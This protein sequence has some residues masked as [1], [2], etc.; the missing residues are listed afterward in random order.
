[1]GI[2][3]DNGDRISLWESLKVT[4]SMRSR[5]CSIPMLKAR[6]RVEPLVREQEVVSPIGIHKYE[7][8]SKF[9]GPMEGKPVTGHAVVELVGDWN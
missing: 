9:A 4:R 7:G 8:A 2:S 3:L 6:L 5:R 1:M